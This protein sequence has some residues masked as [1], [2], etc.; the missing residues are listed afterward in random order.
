MPVPGGPEVAYADGVY[1]TPSGRIELRSEEAAARWGCDPLPRPHLPE[2][3]TARGDAKYPLQM[4]TPNTKNRIHS[5]FGNLALIRQF[6]LMGV[7]MVNPMSAVAI[8]RNKFLTQQTLTAAG[9]PCPDTLFV[10][11]APGVFHAPDLAVRVDRQ[12]D[13]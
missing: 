6:E 13:Q 4:M 10:N 5:Q 7:P 8:T 12:V 1:P 3:T 2:E 11:E 9:L